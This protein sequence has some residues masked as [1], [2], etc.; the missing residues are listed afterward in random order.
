MAAGVEAAG[1]LEA[2]YC[3]HG[4]WALP[5]PAD[6]DVLGKLLGQPARGITAGVTNGTDVHSGTGAPTLASNRRNRDWKTSIPNLS[7]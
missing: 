6:H 5:D 1:K 7:A 3:H 4:R 2:Y